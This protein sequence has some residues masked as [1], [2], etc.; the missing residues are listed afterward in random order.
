MTATLTRPA[1][2]PELEVEIIDKLIAQYAPHFPTTRLH[3]ARP[4]ITKEELENFCNFRIG[5]A[6]HDLN[7]FW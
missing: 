2:I 5:G 1:W 4:P 7:C 3:S 6:A